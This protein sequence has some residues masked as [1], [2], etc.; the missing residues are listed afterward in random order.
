MAAKV[1][2]GLTVQISKKSPYVQGQT[3]TDAATEALVDAARE[4]RK[5]IRESND[6]DEMFEVATKFLEFLATF[7]DDTAAVADLSARLA[8]K[9]WTVFIDD[10]A[11]EFDRVGPCDAP[12]K[13]WFLC[14][15]ATLTKTNDPILRGRVSKAFITAKF[16]P[17]GKY[18][19]PELA[20]EDPA[21]ETVYT[22]RK[23][24]SK[25]IQEETT[26]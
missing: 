22:L 15:L 8:Q 13:T 20:I 26:L 21:V 12:S 4:H 7:I 9:A 23:I 6:P 10:T 11:A 25:R 18:L 14:W 17:P 5:Q 19:N 3:I 16:G 1:K 2:K 24:A